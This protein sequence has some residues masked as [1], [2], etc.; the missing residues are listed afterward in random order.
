MDECLDRAE[1]GMIDLRLARSGS[2]FGR[3]PIGLWRS[4]QIGRRQAGEV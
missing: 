4:R 1:D 3:C 2:F